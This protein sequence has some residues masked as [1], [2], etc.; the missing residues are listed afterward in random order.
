MSCK[1]NLKRAAVACCAL[2]AVLV[3]TPAMAKC[4][5]QADMTSI[6]TNESVR[7]TNWTMFSMM[8]TTKDYALV[9][10][11]SE[12]E[13]K[14]VGL[15][16]HVQNS[17]P[18]RPTKE[19]LDSAVVIPEG[20]KALF[21]MADDSVVELQSEEEQVGD[22]DLVMKGVHNYD[23]VTDTIVRFPTTAEDLEALTAQRVKQIRLATT[24][25]DLDFEFGK[26]GSKK[27]QKV[28]ECIR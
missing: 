5:Y 7:W 3:A 4:K 14:Y 24:N 13:R 11:M 19:D 15:R 23:I 27:M 6:V 18:E 1:A 2:A 20:A 8:I 22:T 26:K 10:G 9:N 12:G 25:G 21:L 16:L 17:A 28:L